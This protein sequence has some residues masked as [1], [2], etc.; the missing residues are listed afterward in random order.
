MPAEAR[1]GK[2]ITFEG[3]EGAGK[4]TQIKRLAARLASKG[5]NALVTREPGGT[6]VGWAVRALL[7]SKAAEKKSERFHDLMESLSNL[8]EPDSDDSS[9]LNA[10]AAL[11][12][13]LGAKLDVSTE[14][15]LL[16]AARAEHW[17][18]AIN[19]MLSSGRW[20][21]CDRFADSTM[22]YQGVAGGLKRARVEAIAEAALPGVKPD[23]TLIFDIDP[24]AG[25]ARAAATRSDTSRFEE[26][27]LSYHKKVRQAFLDIAAREPQRCVVIDAAKDMD[28]VSADVW[29]AA[30]PL[31]EPATTA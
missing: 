19:P 13:A 12:N 23:L 22:A 8:V 21:L 29:A 30:A 7:V 15:L 25:L 6:P 3:G 2:F 24:E 17:H 16:Y 9:A 10:Y 4:S 14:A 11:F 31:L 5:R 18:E 26:L 20:V 28:A 27:D 1:R